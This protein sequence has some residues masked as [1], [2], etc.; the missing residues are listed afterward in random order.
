MKP[1]RIDPTKACNQGYDVRSDVWSLGITLYE[2]STGKFP[3]PQWKSIFHQLDLVV[4]SDAPRLESERLT[5]EFKD[6]VNTCLTK[7]EKMRPKY[8]ELLN[9]PLILIHQGSEVNT[10]EYFEPYINEMQSIEKV[11]L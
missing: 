9:H 10:G 2:L 3:Y 8:K 7:D 11:H 6:F 5:R 4:G 1:E